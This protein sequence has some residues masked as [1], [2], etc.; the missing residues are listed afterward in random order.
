MT[1]ARG[2]ALLPLSSLAHQDVALRVVTHS[3]ARVGWEI[4]SA[5][6]D[7]VRGKVAMCIF[8]HDGRWLHLS[9]EAE[10]RASVERWQRGRAVDR[11]RGRLGFQADVIK[12]EFLGRMR[13]NGAQSALRVLCDYV[14]ENPAPGHAAL[15]AADVHAALQSLLALEVSS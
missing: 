1:S 10:G 13:C 15:P 5:D 8:R 12:D 11:H 3:L 6:I 2:G 7:L 14:A 9:A 4:R